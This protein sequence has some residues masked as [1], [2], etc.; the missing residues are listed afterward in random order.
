MLPNFDFADENMAIVLEAAHHQVSENINR[1]TI[2][3]SY[4]EKVEC[5]R[6]Q[7]LTQKHIICIAKLAHTMF[8]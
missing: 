5:G 1:H 2:R 8:I 4:K 6:R 3:I 7:H